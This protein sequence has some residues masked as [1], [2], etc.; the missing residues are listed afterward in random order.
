MKDK[1]KGDILKIKMEYIRQLYL[2][3]AKMH[4]F[5]EFSDATAI[6]L[7]LNVVKK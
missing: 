5:L 1:A 4:S 6:H 2:N 3:T 7:K